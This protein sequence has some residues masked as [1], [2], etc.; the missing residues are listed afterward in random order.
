V[1]HGEPQFVQHLD[2][3]LD[4]ESEGGPFVCVTVSDKHRNANGVVHGS[5]VHGLLDTVMGMQCY[6]AADR[7]PVATVEISVRFLRPVFDGRLQARARV[8]KAGK[9]LVYVEGEVQREGVM[10]A[11]AQATFARVGGA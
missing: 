3:E 10:V 4:R 2:F 8:L 1:P 9:H 6:R 11:A 7:Q 5:V